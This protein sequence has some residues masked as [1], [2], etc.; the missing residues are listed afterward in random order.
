MYR[1]RPQNIWDWWRTDGHQN[2]NVMRLYKKLCDSP[3]P[4]LQNGTDHPQ[5]LIIKNLTVPQACIT[6]PVATLLIGMDVMIAQGELPPATQLSDLTVYLRGDGVVDGWTKVY[7]MSFLIANV[8]HPRR[9][10]N[11]LDFLVGNLDEKNT[12]EWAVLAQELGPG[13][14]RIRELVAR[15]K[16]VGD[17]A[18]LLAAE[19]GLTTNDVWIKDFNSERMWH[20]HHAALTCTYLG[21]PPG[22]V[23]LAKQSIFSQY[24]YWPA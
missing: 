23:V 18:F 9:P 16:T 2:A 3:R 13:I 4:P 15:M 12:I 11:C 14:Q 21:C 6:D 5:S 7:H 10:N 20:A 22:P 19:R 8:N 17:G 24:W 1:K